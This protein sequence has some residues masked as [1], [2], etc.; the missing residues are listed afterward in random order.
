MV[1]YGASR[2]THPTTVART[3]REAA[4]VEAR[5]PYAC[6]MSRAFLMIYFVAVILLAWWPWNFWLL[7]LGVALGRL[8]QLGHQRLL[9][10]SAR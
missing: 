1:G 9:D 7:V 3:G 4:R 8:L 2:L 10:A 6:A 5:P